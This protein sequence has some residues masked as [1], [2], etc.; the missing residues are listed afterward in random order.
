MYLHTRPT[1]RPAVSEVLRKRFKRGAV[2]EFI[3]AMRNL[4]YDVSGKLC[5]EYAFPFPSV[6][7]GMMLVAML[8]SRIHAKRGIVCHG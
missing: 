4:G 8:F 6:R 7:E 2:T 1:P 3:Q 5:V